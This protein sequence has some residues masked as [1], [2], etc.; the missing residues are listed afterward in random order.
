MIYPLCTETYTLFE[1]TSHH[2]SRYLGQ[3]HKGFLLDSIYYYGIR[4]SGVLKR[5]SGMVKVPLNERATGPR[6]NT[7]PY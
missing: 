7:Q 2:C 6:R 3:G 1:V 5:R 4:R